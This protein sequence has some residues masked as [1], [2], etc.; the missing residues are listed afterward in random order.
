MNAEAKEAAEFLNSYI[1][2]NLIKVAEVVKENPSC[3]KTKAVA[4]LLGVSLDSVKTYLRNGGD[5]EWHGKKREK[6][7]TATAVRPFSFYVAWI[8]FY[9]LCNLYQIFLYVAI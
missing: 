4:D 7:T 8:F 9:N 6:K 2:E 3:I 1:E 5:L